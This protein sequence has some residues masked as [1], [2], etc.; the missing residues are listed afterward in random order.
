MTD[1]FTET[2]N[3]ISQRLKSET[4]DRVAQ[5]AMASLGMKD[6]LLKNTGSVG[7][8]FSKISPPEPRKQYNF[9]I[10]INSAGLANPIEGNVKSVSRPKFNIEYRNVRYM[11]TVRR[12]LKSISFEPITITIYD[13]MG[14]TVQKAIER[15][16]MKQITGSV[17]QQLLLGHSI[18][19]KS[20]DQ[21]IIDEIVIT[22]G[23]SSLV[24]LTNAGLKTLG[25]VISNGVN[26]IPNVQQLLQDAGVQHMK[27]LN[28]TIEH[29]DFGEFDYSASEPCMITLGIS[30]QA[31]QFGSSIESKAALEIL[32]GTAARIITGGV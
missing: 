22:G 14:G 10:K 13:D 6:A 12:T 1:F 7:R 20:F 32:G 17:E 4:P 11:N 26:G 3:V 19:M 21:S 16:L 23:T 28:C 8:T 9:S 30:Y 15:L 25:G 18:D 2:L 24:Q 29:V 27:L 5:D 31:L